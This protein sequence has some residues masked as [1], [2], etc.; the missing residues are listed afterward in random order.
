[1][2]ERAS[3]ACETRTIGAQHLA[4]EIGEPRYSLNHTDLGFLERRAIQQVMFEVA[5]NKARAARTLGISRTRLYVRLRKH[6]LDDSWSSAGRHG[7]Q[8]DVCDERQSLVARQSSRVERLRA[9]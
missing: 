1:M 9:L 7:D 8:C 6:G 3:I 2:I 5:G 4:L